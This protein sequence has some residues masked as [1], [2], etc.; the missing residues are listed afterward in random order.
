[1]TSFE[2]LE[3]VAMQGCFIKS[4][5]EFLSVIEQQK[6]FLL[7]NKLPVEVRVR[8]CHPWKPVIFVQQAEGGY[9]LLFIFTES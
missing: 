4:A 6:A 3:T 9:R 5:L 1:M 2:S 7:K 8:V